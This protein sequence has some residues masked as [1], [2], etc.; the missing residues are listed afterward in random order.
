[1]DQVKGYDYGKMS[2]PQSPV[3]LQDLSLL[4]KTLLWS[5]DDDRY[6]KMAG[7][8]LVIKPIIF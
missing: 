7:E 3:T 5:D 6:L 2:L 4:K 1:M 8:V